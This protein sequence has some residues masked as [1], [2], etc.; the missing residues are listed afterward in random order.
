MGAPPPPKCC[1]RA[2]SETKPG[3]K[4]CQPATLCTIWRARA[5]PQL[6][7]CEWCLPLRSTARSKMSAT[8]L[9]WSWT[10]PTASWARRV[11][12]RTGHCH[13]HQ[14]QPLHQRH[15][16]HHQPLMTNH[17]RRSLRTCSSTASLWLMMVMTEQPSSLTID[18]E[19]V[20]CCVAVKMR[21]VKSSSAI[22]RGAN[23]LGRA[24]LPTAHRPPR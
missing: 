10:M 2:W 11:K 24:T 9:P 3:R 19:G 8:T 16:L 18:W 13:Q 23:Q 17:V 6:P 1:A 21:S 7:R 5:L 15:P 4:K 22:A 20:S 12:A 14:H